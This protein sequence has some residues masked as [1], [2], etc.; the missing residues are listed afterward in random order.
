M[1]LPAQFKLCSSLGT[2]TAHCLDILAAL[3]ART[4]MA[5]IRVD[6][7][8][9]YFD[10]P[11]LLSV[12]TTAKLRGIETIAT[13]R[14]LKADPGFSETRLAALQSCVENGADYADVEVEAP[15]WYQERLV[16]H[17]RL[18]GAKVIVSHHDYTKSESASEGLREVVEHC[19]ARGADLAKVA[20]HVESTQ[21]AARVLGLYDTARPILAIGMGQHGQIT[22]I[23]AASMGAPFTFV[24]VDAASA[25]A[26]G[27]MTRIAMRQCLLDIGVF[28]G[29]HAA[30]Y[31]RPKV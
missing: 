18:H 14:E 17:C 19:F 16:K 25:T 20:V 28:A 5:E 12:F 3:D 11:A 30:E 9:D 27:Q 13:V 31:K 8:N 26:P 7:L 21:G 15:A 24:A 23:A 4:E 22:R 6:L 29:P 10:S 1:P 2:S